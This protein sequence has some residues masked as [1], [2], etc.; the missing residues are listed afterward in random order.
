[1]FVVVAKKKVKKTV[2]TPSKPSSVVA[3]GIVVVVGGDD[4]VFVDVFV[5]VHVNG[6][7]AVVV[8]VV[9]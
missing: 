7:D 9:P 3:V 4:A 2:G 8:V 6:V 1:M 5:P